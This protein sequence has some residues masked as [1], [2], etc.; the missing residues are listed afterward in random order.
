MTMPR[1]QQ[2]QFQQLLT[3]LALSYLAEL[4]R[5]NIFGP[6]GHGSYLG[7]DVFISG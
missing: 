7:W 5:R 1:D 3:V 6:Q 2:L 4:S